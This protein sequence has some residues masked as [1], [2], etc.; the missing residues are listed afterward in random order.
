MFLALNLDL[1]NCGSCLHFSA[2]FFHIFLAIGK[3]DYVLKGKS[4]IMPLQLCLYTMQGK[5]QHKFSQA[6]EKPQNL[7]LGTKKLLENITYK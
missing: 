7:D 3:I 4:F 2:I 6:A 5:T 1:Q